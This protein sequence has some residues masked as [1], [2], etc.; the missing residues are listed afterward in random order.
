MN[1]IAPKI[2]SSPD[3]QATTSRH[4]EQTLVTEAIA[5]NGQAFATLVRPHLPVLLRVAGRVT[6]DAQLAEDVV[7]ETLAATFRQLNRYEV[8][9]SLRAFM[10][11][12]A[13]R[14]AHTLARGERRRAS[15]EERAAVPEAE[16][17]AEQRLEAL[18]KAQTVHGI[19]NDMPRKRREA[20]IL[21]LDAGLS[22]AEIAR[23]MGT[24]E[25]STRVL[26]HL[27]LKEL[28]EQLREVSR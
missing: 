20:A 19:L 26:V 5:G 23:T 1:E 15:R 27:A 18:Q 25:G 2:R 24:S 7:Q 10:A 6:G 16:P 17:S 14:R 11:A 12:I 8:G 28:R 13:V 9:T 21:R 3:S 22:F 4:L